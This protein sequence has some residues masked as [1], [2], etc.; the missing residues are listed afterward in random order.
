MEADSGTVCLQSRFLYQLHFSPVPHSDRLIS[1]RPSVPLGVKDRPHG[2]GALPV[3]FFFLHKDSF[4]YI[5]KKE[6]ERGGEK[7]VLTLF[8]QPSESLDLIPVENTR[9]RLQ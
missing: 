9:L 8:P 5:K 1:P 4:F 6:R 3:S 7:V 2:K